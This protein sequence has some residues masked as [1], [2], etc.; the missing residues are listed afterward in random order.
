MNFI[1]S[2]LLFLAGIHFMILLLAYGYRII[3]LWYRIGDYWKGIV[4]NITALLAFNVLVIYILP[5]EF[6]A[7]WIYG[8]A[9]YLGFHVV[10]FWIARLALWLLA[11][12][13]R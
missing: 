13:Y 7:I 1:L 3:D 2:V 4:A 10:I 9:V 11:S 6:K 12:K 8:Q 5:Q